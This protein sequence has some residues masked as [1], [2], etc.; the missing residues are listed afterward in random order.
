M[1]VIYRLEMLR[2]LPQNASLLI[3][4]HFSVCHE[5]NLSDCHH[6]SVYE[7]HAKQSQMKCRVSQSCLRPLILFHIAKNG[8][9]VLSDMVKNTYRERERIG[10]SKLNIYYYEKRKQFLY[11][12]VG[13]KGWLYN[14]TVVNIF[15]FLRLHLIF[16]VFPWLERDSRC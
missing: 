11:I 13:F 14:Q 5:E 3:C 9:Q 8:W 2:I 10:H 1:L 6:N 7:E 4:F 15:L 16:S 12:F